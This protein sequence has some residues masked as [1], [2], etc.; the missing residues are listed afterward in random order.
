VYSES[1]VSVTRVQ[2]GNVLFGVNEWLYTATLAS[3]VHARR[4]FIEIFNNTGLGTDDWFWETGN[5]DSDYGTPANGFAF[6]APG[7]TWNCPLGIDMAMVI[8]GDAPPPP[9]PPPANECPAG[10]IEEMDQKAN[11]SNGYLSEESCNLCGGPQV[12]AED[13]TIQVPIEMQ[14]LNLTGG[15]FPSNNPGTGDSFTVRILGDSGGVPDTSNVIYDGI[16]NPVTS[17]RV[18]T[19]NFLFGV[20]E[21]YHT[22]ALAGMVTLPA[23]KIWFEVYNNTTS[24]PDDWFWEVGNLDSNN[25]TFGSAFDFNAPGVNWTFTGVD[26][27]IRICVDG[28]IGTKYC[29]A[30]DNSTGNPALI[31]AFPAGAVD[32]GIVFSAESTPNEHFLLFHG[33]NQAV[34]P[35]GNGYLC[36]TGNLMR[37]NVQKGTENVFCT[38][39]PGSELVSL[40]GQT[41]NF[42]YWFRDPMAGGSLFNTSDAVSILIAPGDGKQC[43]LKK[44]VQKKKVP[45]SNPAVYYLDVAGWAGH[46]NAN[47]PVSILLMDGEKPVSGPVHTNTNQFGDFKSKELDLTEGKKGNKIR[48][49]VNGKIKWSSTCLQ[50]RNRFRKYLNGALASA[51]S[52]SAVALSTQNEARRERSLVRGIGDQNAE[53]T[54]RRW[55]G[56]PSSRPSMA[57]EKRPWKWRSWDSVPAGSVAGGK[58]TVSLPSAAIVPTNVT[59]RG[60]RRSMVPRKGARCR[61]SAACERQRRTPSPGVPRNTSWVTVPSRT[62]RSAVRR[63]R[64]PG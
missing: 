34:I 36:T 33:Q 14:S 32:Q 15:Y 44:P 3:T 23:G 54:T 45:N 21:W 10:A 53:S 56:L 24:T 1:Y 11:A 29:M 57:F 49:V 61:S 59:A 7:I 43:F 2:T 41:R 4:H 20:D 50:R 26:L 62:T 30:T 18:M 39:L 46:E 58:D 19:G 42:Q 31:K 25:G 12:L 47:K 16:A 6:N 52:A 38:I 17:S 22:I 55:V 48:I 60:G 13:I 27:A 9:P 8:C 28:E 64:V 5:L 51:R 40:Y 37:W 63:R 35:F